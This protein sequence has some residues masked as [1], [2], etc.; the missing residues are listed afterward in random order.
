[1]RKLV[2]AL[3]CFAVAAGLVA[4]QQ[5]NLSQA[6]TKHY[7][8]LSG[9]GSADATAIANEL[10]AY[11]ALFDSYFHFDPQSLTTRLKVRIFATKN[12]FNTYLGQIIPGTH[13]SFVYLQY[14][15]PAQ[16]VLVGYHMPDARSFQTQLIHHGFV[17]F[18]RSF[19]PNPPL[20]LEEGFAVYFENTSYDPSKQVAVFH[21]NLAWLPM[22]QHSLS[23][24]LS[25]SDSTSIILPD[26]LLTV[27]ADQANAKIQAFYSESWGLVSFLL[28]SDNKDMNRLMWEAIG[29]LSPKATVAENEQAI[30]K[31][32]FAWVPQATLYQE[33]KNYI[34]SEKT[35]PELVQAGMGA[36][37]GGNTKAA[38]SDFTKAI[39]IDSTNYVP[40]YYLGLIHYAG[41]DY[42]LAEQYFQTA[43]QMGGDPGLINYALGVTA[44]ADNRIPDAKKYLTQA[45]AVSASTY[46]DQAASLLDRINSQTAQ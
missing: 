12:D 43:L 4:A 44:F 14:Q 3:V 7:D 20:W 45:E 13:D 10:E 15:D 46:K 28:N 5:T 17:Q 30:Q 9:Q 32:A 41:K 23:T 29:A 24:F 26:A 21:P 8:V 2:L 1:M 40:Y 36:Y 42:Y 34:E 31:D 37:A 19:V 16:S 33:F 38:E 35:F 22:L 18:L 11:F 27:N 25:T 39:A 6:E